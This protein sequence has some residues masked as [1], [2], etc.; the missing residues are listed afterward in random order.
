MNEEETMKLLSIS[1]HNFLSFEDLSLGLD[2][3]GLVLLDGTN[4]DSSDGAFQNNGVG[5][6][7][8]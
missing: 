5:K 2:N 8:F 6:S 1:V 7:T 3:Q 4:K